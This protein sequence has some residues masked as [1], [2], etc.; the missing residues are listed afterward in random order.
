VRAPLQGRPCWLTR[1]R[2]RGSGQGP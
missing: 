2:R 1:F